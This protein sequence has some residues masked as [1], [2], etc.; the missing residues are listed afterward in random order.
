MKKILA[1]NSTDEFIRIFAHL[2]DD[3]TIDIVRQEQQFTIIGTDYILIG[4]NPQGG[5]KLVLQVK[6]G[7][8]NTDEINFLEENDNGKT[9]ET[10]TEG[11]RDDTGDDTSAGD[12]AGDG[13]ENGGDTTGE[14]ATEPSDTE[15][16]GR[17][18][19][20]K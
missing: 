1:S 7:K 4:T 6:D 12:N 17:T 10:E 2:L 8:L 13:R 16:T 11:T 3:G 18:F 14:P 19:T 20:T 5:G 15:R 9:T